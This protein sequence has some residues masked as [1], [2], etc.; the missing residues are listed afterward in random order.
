MSVYRKNNDGLTLDYCFVKYVRT[1]GRKR[2]AS[3]SVGCLQDVDEDS[4]QHSPE[5]NICNSTPQPRQGR[6]RRS[7][8]YALFR[9]SLSS[10]SK[11]YYWKSGF[12]VCAVNGEL[13]V[14]SSEGYVPVDHSRQKLSSP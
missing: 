7:S 14:T 2:N 1:C 3:E 8:T 9:M 12:W 6:L 11:Y 10:K 13:N 4:D 5:E